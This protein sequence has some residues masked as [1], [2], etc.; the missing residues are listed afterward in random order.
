MKAILLRSAAVISLLTAAA[1]GQTI[2]WG[3]EAFSTLVDS[4]NRQLGLFDTYTFELGT[5]SSGFDPMVSNPLLWLANWRVF[6]AAEY[7]RA[8][9]YFT[10]TVEMNDNGSSASADRSDAL[11]F[12]GAAY[13]WI[14]NAGVA[15]SLTTEWLLV[16]NSSW[17]FPA[18]NSHCCDPDLP[19][20]WSVSDLTGIDVPVYGAQKDEA[21]AYQNG[22]ISSQPAAQVGPYLQTATFAPVPELSSSVLIMVLGVLGLLDR[23]RTWSTSSS[24]RQPL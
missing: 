20:E 13:V 11:P 1:H 6:D 24:A 8:N 4:Q 19:V 23:R 17:S 12:T 22:L 16:R 7:N 18:P 3:S 15:Q 21:I 5:F 14:R 9:G 2:N 10:S